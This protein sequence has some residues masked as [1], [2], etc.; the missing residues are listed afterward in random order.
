MQMIS[1]CKACHHLS[2][3]I[4]HLGFSYCLASG[5]DTNDERRD[6]RN[7]IFQFMSFSLGLMW[8]FSGLSGR[9][10]LSY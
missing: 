5:F 4:H 7:I 2:P 3:S 10:F 8:I 9:W 1:L 6:F